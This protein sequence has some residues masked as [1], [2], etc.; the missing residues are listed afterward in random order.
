MAKYLKFIFSFLK[1]KKA[2]PKKNGKTENKQKDEI[3]P[4]F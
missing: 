1:I 4:L 2:T 3:Y